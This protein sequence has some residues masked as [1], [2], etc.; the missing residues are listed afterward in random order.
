MKNKQLKKT[1]NFFLQSLFKPLSYSDIYKNLN[2][3]DDSILKLLN[4]KCYFNEYGTYLDLAK[5]ERKKWKEGDNYNS[6]YE[7]TKAIIEYA[8]KK[9]LE[10]ENHLLEKLID[11]H[12]F[13]DHSEIINA[14][15]SQIKEETPKAHSLKLIHLIKK[16]H[17]TLPEDFIFSI[18][19]GP[20][21][22]IPIFLSNLPVNIHAKNEKGHNII[23]YLSD[24]HY[25]L[26]YGPN[27]IAKKIKAFTKHGLKLED[28]D[29][30]GKNCLHIAIQSCNSL[31]NLTLVSSLLN[32]KDFKDINAKTKTGLNYD[33]LTDNSKIID[34][35]NKKRIELEKEKLEKAINQNPI[36]SHK[37]PR[38][39]I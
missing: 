26:Y 15:M 14:I 4:K 25:F 11:N 1:I 16:H 33:D 21:K 22:H 27:A 10:N 3:N 36:I 2:K 38:V 35:L 19:N 12:F 28:V 23:Q 30:E 17:L 24:V 20:I 7:N 32:R 29:L 13:N 18:S 39:K 34:M 5:I 8:T 31:T 6:L 9:Y 37:K